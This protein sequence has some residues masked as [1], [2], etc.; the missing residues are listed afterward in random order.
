M[1]FDYIAKD[2]SV[3][4]LPNQAKFAIDKTIKNNDD[5][6]KRLKLQSKDKLGENVD[7]QL[8]EIQWSGI[9]MWKLPRKK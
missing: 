5:N 3:I 7:R 2:G 1:T 6:R 4:N 8:Y 9:S